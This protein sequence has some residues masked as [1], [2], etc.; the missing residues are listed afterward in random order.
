[1]GKIYYAAFLHKGGYG[2]CKITSR[3]PIKTFAEMEEA[4][5]TLEADNNLKEVVIINLIEMVGE[6][7]RKED[8]G[9]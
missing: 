7:M 9:K 5:K 6:D 1:M 2:K 4:I 3:K 8:E